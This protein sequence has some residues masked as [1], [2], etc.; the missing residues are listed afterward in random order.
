MEWQE[1][2]NAFPNKWV[3][4]EAVQA[5]TT[6]QK[7]RV[8]TKIVPIETYSEPLSAMNEYKKMQQSHPNRELYVLH[9]D[10]EKLG[11]IEKTWIG[12]R[13]A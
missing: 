10:R 11:I 1:V 13:R 2:R 7:E 12:V 9:T 3:L 5:F 6:D 4:F 8:L